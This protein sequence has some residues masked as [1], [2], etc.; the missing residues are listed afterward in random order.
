MSSVSSTIQQVFNEPAC[1]KNANKTEA[2]RKK[3]CTKQLQP[4]GAAGGCAFDGA[5]IALQP[6]T[7]VAHLVHGPIACEGNS[8]DNRGA[9][10]SGSNVWRTGFT[11]D[12]NETDVV[13]GGEKRLYKAIKEIFDKHNPEAVFVYQT[14]VPA[15]IGDDIDAVCKAAR[16]KLGKP[17]IP[18]NSPGFVGPKNL[19]N[20]LAGEALL[21]HVIGTEEPEYTTPYDLNIIG[22]YNLSGELWQ[23]KPLLDELG[24]RILSCISGDGKYHEVAQSHRAKASMMVCSKAMINVARKMEDKYGIPFFEGSFYG[25]EDSSDSLREIARLLIQRGAPEEL[26]ERTEK[27]IE[28]EEAKA[29]AAIAKYK[30]RFKGKKVLLITGGVKSWSVVSALQEAGLELVGTSV[31]KSTKEDKERIKELMGQDAHML[32]D[33]SPRDMYKMLKDARADIMLSGGRSQFIALKA[34]MPWLDINQERH[35]AYMGYVGMVKLVQEID[36]ALYNPIWEQV[37]KPAPWED[38]NNNWQAKA[39]AQ[40]E[41][42]AAELAKDPVAA[43]KARRSKKICNCKS[44]D[45]GTIEDAIKANAL[46]NVEGVRKHTNASGGCGSCAGRVEDILATMA[47]AAEAAPAPVLEAAE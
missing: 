17:V 26:M 9:K 43:E 29:W 30:P 37:R 46:T 34:S 18:I 10:S 16:E 12:I 23:V 21:Q 13:F 39:I 2:E 27:V 11:T 32:D 44:V 40:I 7:D 3:G 41:A 42:E 15:M 38:V 6:L 19:G 24:I 31:K 5:K 4:G 14:C 20:K 25:I 33:M 28:R 36:K 35:N 47:V 45:L 22:E 1:A 8:W